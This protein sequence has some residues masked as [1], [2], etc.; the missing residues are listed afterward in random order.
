MEGKRIIHGCVDVRGVLAWPK[1]MLRGM[2]REN[3]K[4]L[5][6]DQAR[7]YL[8]D[9]LAQGHLVLPMSNPPCEGFS[10]EA[11]CPGHDVAESEA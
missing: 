7:D 8:L 1:R 4:T 3:G 6:P 2:F 5:T 9:E 11:G 10:Y